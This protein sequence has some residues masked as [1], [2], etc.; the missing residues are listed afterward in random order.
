[1]KRTLEGGCKGMCRCEMCQAFE[2][3]VEG[4]IRVRGIALN[5]VTIDPGSGL[6]EDVI[7]MVK[8]AKLQH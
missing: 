2:W 8:E 1:M 4:R 7:V 6:E 5:T 3:E